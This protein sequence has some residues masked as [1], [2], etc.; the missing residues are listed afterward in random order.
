MRKIAITGATGLVGTRILEILKNDFEFIPLR[1]EDID[2]TDKDKVQTKFKELSFDLLLHLAAYT[3]VDGAETEKETAHKINVEGTQ[4]VLKATLEKN[5]QFIY[6]STGFIFDGKTPPYFEDS[7]PN[8]I[9]YYGQTKFEGEKAVGDKGMI[10]RFEYPYGNSPAPKKDFARV[11][12]TLLEQGRTIKGISNSLMTPTFIDDIAFALKHLVENFSPEI[13]H[14]VGSQSI[15]PFD[16][17]KII[18]KTFNL[19][20][21]LIQS[22]T[23]EEYFAGKAKR[24]QFADVRSNKNNFL[25]MKS[26]EEGVKLLK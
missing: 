12:K 6:I 10:V 25:K 7:T 15:S 16:A 18:A 9:G 5:A 4:N 3:N 24:P 22:T 17:A 1:S 8:P 11:L 19:D 21:N 23:Y 26:F 2:I 14:V 20:T 13:F